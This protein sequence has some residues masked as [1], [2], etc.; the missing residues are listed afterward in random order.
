MSSEHHGE[1]EVLSELLNEV[2][3]LVGRL[4]SLDQLSQAEEDEEKEVSADGGVTLGPSD[5]FRLREV[6]FGNVTF[7]LISFCC[8]LITPPHS[9]PNHVQKIYKISISTES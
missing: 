5:R 8:T 4:A 3:L 1:D 2:S 7:V 9:L 6:C